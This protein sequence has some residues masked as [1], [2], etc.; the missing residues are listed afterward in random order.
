MAL[1]G[2]EI[3]KLLPRTNCKKCGFQT[4]LAFAMQLAKKAVSLDKCP[5]VDG[6]VRLVLEEASQPAIRLIEIGAGDN[7]VLAGNETVL[8]RHEQ[9]FH[10]PTLIGLIFDDDMK[11]ADLDRAL[12]EVRGLSFERVGQKIAVDLICLRGET[13]NKE[14][15]LT[16]LSRIRQQSKLGLV[17]MPAT[18][19]ILRDAL[20]VCAQ[21]KPL[22]S[23]ALTTDLGSFA[24]LCREYKVS[25]AFG[26]TNLN[27][28]ADGAKKL[29]QEGLSE[30]VFDISERRPSI[31]HFACPAPSRSVRTTETSRVPPPKSTMQYGV[32]SRTISM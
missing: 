26:A 27:E 16:S 30:I 10:H 8:F 13:K 21:D 31:R 11:E 29:T 17:L 15:F 9:K 14:K 23:S 1:S 19:E 20:K 18:A 4:C 32:R 12:R 6:K 25:L 28:F 22:V 7:K 5:L 3:Y 24:S 2:L